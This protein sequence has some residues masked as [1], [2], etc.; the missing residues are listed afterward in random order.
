MFAE[1]T[2]ILIENLINCSMKI[3][4]TGG[5]GDVR[6]LLNRLLSEK[7][8]ILTLYHSEPGNA[9]QFNCRQIDLAD[10]PALRSVIKCFQPDVILHAAAISSVADCEQA[11]REKV[12]NVNV[13]VS[14]TIAE[15]CNEQDIKMFYYSTDLV[16]GGEQGSFI[17]EA[18]KINPK[19]LYAESKYL[20]EI[21]VR[22]STDNCTI[23]RTALMIGT[24]N[25]GKVNHF[26]EVLKNLVS[27]KAVKLFTDQFR[28]P[29][30]LEEAAELTWELIS[31]KES[32]GV[33]NF[34]GCDRVSRFEIG[35]LVCEIGG[36]NKSL[37]RGVTM[38]E[39][40]VTYK[41]PDVSM[42]ISKLLSIGCTPKTIQTQIR[43][44]LQRFSSLKG[45]RGKKK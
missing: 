13:S 32:T 8:K 36:F 16:Y 38:D 35:E 23:L 24:T 44:E 43:C 31:T 5:G 2:F 9:T 37:L 22:E 10:V 3:L 39:F 18:G 25:I 34:G 40:D 6:L 11:G 29:L 41:V 28:T 27:G 1:F 20:G 45:H 30:S 33:I 17:S 14:R 4:I 19:S 7:G 26:G 42:N 12:M 21:A 15:L